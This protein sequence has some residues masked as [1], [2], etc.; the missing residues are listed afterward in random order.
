MLGATGSLITETK[1]L[2]LAVMRDETEK[3]IRVKISVILSDHQRNV[4]LAGIGGLHLESK[5]EQ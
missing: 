4:Y 1:G 5:R 3:Q 2:L